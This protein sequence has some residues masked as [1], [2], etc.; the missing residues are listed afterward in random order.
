MMGRAFEFHG[1]VTAL[2]ENK[3]LRAQLDLAKK[4]LNYI[5][6]RVNYRLDTYG[7]KMPYLDNG[8]T[9]WD[10]AAHAL[11]ELDRI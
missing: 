9:V 2:E 11:E 10:Y 1:S 7:L 8:D 3:R 6:R 5:A 4:A